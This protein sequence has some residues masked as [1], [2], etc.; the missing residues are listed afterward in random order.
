MAP[1]VKAET[2]GLNSGVP[3]GDS[4]FLVQEQKIKIKNKKNRIKF[5]PG[6]M[7]K[8]E[9]FFCIKDRQV[10]FL[11]IEILSF[12]SGSVVKNG[13]GCIRKYFN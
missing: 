3:E 12:F 11:T 5:F 4:V 1:E 7:T 8:N 2:R 13:I 9:I 10:S 6:A